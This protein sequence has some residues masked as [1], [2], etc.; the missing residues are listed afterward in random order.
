MMGI[1]SGKAAAALSGRAAVLNGWSVEL[2]GASAHALYGARFG[3][4]LVPK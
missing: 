1:R 2:T 3:V 4:I